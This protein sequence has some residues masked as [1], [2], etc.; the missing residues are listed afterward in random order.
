MLTLFHIYCAKNNINLLFPATQQKPCSF[1]IFDIYHLLIRDAFVTSP[2]TF[3]R[4][5]CDP[6]GMG[7][8]KL[9]DES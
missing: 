6:E 1:V 9:H 5:I 3:S 7:E 8:A 2:L 4:V